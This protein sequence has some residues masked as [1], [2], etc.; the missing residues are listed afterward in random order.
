MDDAKLSRAMNLSVAEGALAT[1]MGTLAGGVFLTGFALSMG[2]TGLQ[3][4]VLAALPVL[5]NF[6]QIAGACWIE[7]T[8]ERKRFCLW[9][10]LVSRLLW[11][12]LLLVPMLLPDDAAGHR[13]WWMAAALGVLSVL[14]SM[15]GVAWLS[16]IK[17]LIPAPSRVAF[18][19]RRHLFNTALS[20]AMGML[21]AFYLDWTRAADPASLTGF[22][23]VLAVAMACGLVGLPLLGSIPAPPPPKPSPQSLLT[24]LTSPLREGNFRRLVTFY[25]VWNLSVHLAQPFFAV[26]MLEKLGLSFAAVT[27]LAMLSSIIGLLANGFWVRL[28]ERFGTKPIVLIATLGD[29]LVPLGWLLVSPSTSWLLVPI[30]CWGVFNAPLST[31]PNNILLKLSPEQGAAPYLATFNAVVGPVSAIASVLGGLLLASFGSAVWSLGPLDLGGLKTVFL[32]SCVGRLVSLILLWRVEEP[33]SLPVIHV[34]HA[35]KPRLRPRPATVTDDEPAPQPVA[36]AA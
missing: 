28:T 3:I 32:L 10:S 11:L 4:G 36:T 5:A 1:V 21:G 9:T 34:F 16:W 12:P 24:R 17:D 18:L 33:A 8:G 35:L 25:M 31:G 19:G 15:S 2:A 14:A 7:W 27:A 23:V 13:V 20:L 29:V 26:Y 30:H 6:A 22:I